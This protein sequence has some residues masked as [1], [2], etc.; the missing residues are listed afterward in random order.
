MIRTEAARAELQDT[1]VEGPHRI[2]RSMDEH[3]DPT[4]GAHVLPVRKQTHQ[5]KL[6]L[7]R[8]VSQPLKSAPLGPN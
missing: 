1:P 3:A 6:G 4:I 7:C 8:R 2:G 5:S